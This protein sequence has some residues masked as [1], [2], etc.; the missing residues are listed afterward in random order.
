MSTHDERWKALLAVA[1]RMAGGEIEVRAELS[2]ARDEVDALAHAINVVVGELSYMAAGYARAK[3]EAEQRTA[4]LAATQKALLRKERLAVLGQLS[5]GVAHQIRNPLAAILN[6]TSILKRHVGEDAHPDA[7]ESLDI[8]QDEI[9]HAN[10]II[11]GLLDFAR[12]RAPKRRATHLGHLV[13]GTLDAAR[14]PPEVRVECRV[15]EPVPVLELDADHVREALT[16]LL[17][18]AVEAMPEGGVLGVEVSVVDGGAVLA[19]TDTGAGVS[20]DDWAR[21]FEPLHSTKPFG[22]GLGLVTARTLVEAHAGQL[23]A[24]PSARGARFEIRLPR[25]PEE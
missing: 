4:E 21:I 25:R 3:E 22:V 2:G 8:I 18:N 15:E 7:R 13:R 10:A 1:E 11:T 23:V 19:V 14:I 5:G 6:A 9:R 24:V 17:R 16:N 20:E 12:F